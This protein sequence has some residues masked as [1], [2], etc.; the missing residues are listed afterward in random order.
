MNCQIIPFNLPTYLATYFGNKLSSKKEVLN[1]G[2]YEDPFEVSGFSEYGNLILKSIKPVNSPYVYNSSDKLFISFSDRAGSYIKKR[3]VRLDR[4]FWELSGE[5]LEN[6]EKT[7][8]IVFKS[9]LSL[10]VLGAERINKGVAK[11]NRTDA[12]RDFCEINNVIYSD[13]NLSTWKKMCQRNNNDPKKLIY[14]L[15]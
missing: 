12:I 11:R 9:H 13:T 3:R 1:S 5:D 14:S 7:L 8:S 4:Y 15:L 10:F 2:S 6:V